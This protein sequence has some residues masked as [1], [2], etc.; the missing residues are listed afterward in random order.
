MLVLRQGAFM[1]RVSLVTLVVS[2][3]LSWLSAHAFGLAGAAVGSVTAVYIDYVVILRR[4]ALC[5]GTPVRRLKDWRTLGLLILFAALA[6]A[7][8]W[9]M[10]DRYFTASG[11]LVRLIF[12]G[13]LLAAVYTAMAAAGMGRSLL[14]A[15]RNPGHGL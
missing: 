5:T 8:A 10:V 4:I 7:I 1:M 2:V 15:V 12:G 14:A 6:A 3:A 13:A 9:G 11:P